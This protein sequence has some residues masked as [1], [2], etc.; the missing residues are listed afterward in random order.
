MT[1][2]TQG[3][4]SRRLAGP[5]GSHGTCLARAT[6]ESH[7]SDDD[8][9]DD[10]VVVVVEVSVVH[11]GDGGDYD[12]EGS[13]LQSAQASLRQLVM[14]VFEGFN[15]LNVRSGEPQSWFP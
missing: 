7:C 12:D 5:R 14:F 15:L 6:K 2:C 3:S 13:S 11:S 10:E 4:T 1:R 9:D 8:D